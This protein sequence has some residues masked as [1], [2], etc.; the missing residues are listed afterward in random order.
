MAD[1]ETENY[2]YDATSETE[3]GVITGAL[4]SVKEPEEGVYEVEQLHQDIRLPKP[5]PG[6]GKDRHDIRWKWGPVTIVGYVVKSTLEI[7]VEAWVAGIKIGTF[8]GSLKKGLVIRVNLF[9]AKG[10]IKFYLKNGK[11]IWVYVSLS[12]LGKKWSTDQKIYTIG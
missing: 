4:I 1:T 9:I 3:H 7:G 2:S 5:A 8:Y 10:E 12:V 6:L 11:E